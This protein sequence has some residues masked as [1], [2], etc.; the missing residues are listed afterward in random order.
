MAKPPADEAA[1]VAE[2]VGLPRHF[3]HVHTGSDSKLSTTSSMEEE[4]AKNALRSETPQLSPEIDDE[5]AA[6]RVLKSPGLDNLDTPPESEDESDSD[7]LRG[8]GGKG[9]SRAEPSPTADEEEDEDED[10]D[11]EEDINP[12]ANKLQMADAS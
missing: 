12:I 10:E 7:A 6:V 2:A 3:K 1:A 5:N 4:N 9:L 11:E 8:R